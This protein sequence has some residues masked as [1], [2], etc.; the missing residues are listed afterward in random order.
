MG[1]EPNALNESYAD[2]FSLMV[3]N[4]YQ[5][6]GTG[7]PLTESLVILTGI[8]VRIPVLNQAIHIGILEIQWKITVM[9][10]FMKE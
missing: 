5:P 1:C 4:Y 9:R 7:C 3:E 10:C 6:D 2:I 8:L